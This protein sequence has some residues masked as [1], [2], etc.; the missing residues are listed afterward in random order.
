MNL[1]EGMDSVPASFKRT[2]D[3]QNVAVYGD[4]LLSLDSTSG[5]LKQVAGIVLP[6]GTSIMEP[7]N[8]NNPSD[9]IL[10]S[11]VGSKGDTVIHT[12]HID[13][14]Q[15]DKTAT[16]PRRAEIYATD[17]NI[18][19]WQ[20]RQL[21][22]RSIYELSLINRKQRKLFP[23]NTHLAAVRWGRTMEIEYNDGNGKPQKGEVILPPDYKAGQRYPML[24]WVYGGYVSPGVDS[25]WMNPYLPGIYNLQLY[26]AKGYVVLVPS[27]P[28]KFDA[29]KNDPYP[30]LPLGSGLTDQSQKMTVAARA[31][32]EKKALGHRS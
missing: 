29:P 26:A 24:I 27:I 12:L 30:A 7:E 2:A 3:G 8:T 11:S 28:L 20:D 1:T 19:L 22:G 17:H 13:T 6:A 10:L 25:Y 15:L 18:I 31:M 32:A 4:R 14:K 16:L 5:R 9:T 23:F 21:T